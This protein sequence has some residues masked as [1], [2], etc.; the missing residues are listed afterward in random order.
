MKTCKLLLLF[1]LLAPGLAGAHADPSFRIRQNEKGCLIEIPRELLG[2]DFLLGARVV[3]VSSTDSRTK[4]YAGQRLYDPVWV[5]FRQEGEQLLLLRPGEKNVCADTT[6]VSYPAYARNAVTPVAGSWRIEQQSDSSIIVNWT[7]LFGEPMSGV[8]PF[9]GRN[10]EGRLLSQFTRVEPVSAHPT[11]LE[12]NVRYVFEKND[13]TFSTVVRKSLLVLPEEPMKP[14]ID[15]PRVGYDLVSKRIY[16]LGDPSLHAEDYIT[17]FRIVPAPEDVP[18]YLKGQKVK[19]QQPI[20]F[21]IDDAFPPLWK[22]AIRE[23]ILDWNRAFEKIGF[24]E[25]LQTK[26]YAE[27]GPDFDPDDIR[28]NCFRYVVSDFPNAMG[29]HWTDPRSGEILQA[30][31]L[32]HSEVITLLQRWLFLQTA[33]YN[34]DARCKQLPDRVV[35]RLIRY[36]AAHEIGHCLGLEH[37]F[38]A[39]SAYDTESLRDPEFTK[40]CGTTPSIMDYAR[41]NYVAQPGDGVT[42]VYPPLLGPYDEYAIRTGYAYLPDGEEQ[43]VTRW[44]DRA[45]A[46]P[47]LLYGR[48]NPSIV[49]AD[50]TVQSSD[51]G[52]DPVA[53]ASCGT[54]NLRRIL[55]HVAEWNRDRTTENPFEGMPAGYDDLQ[56]AYFDQLERVVPFIGGIVALEGGR[57]MAKQRRFIPRDRSELAV[58]FLWEE[59]I[60]GHAFLHTD[61]VCRYAGDQ[62]VAIV[63]ARKQIVEKMFSRNVAEQI[64]KGEQQTSFGLADYLELSAEA[65]FEEP[66]PDL[67]LRNLQQN[68]IDT[69]KALCKDSSDS[70]YGVLIAPA[71]ADH[72]ALLR[73]KFAGH[74]SPWNNH[75]KNSLP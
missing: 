71:V 41:F 35:E 30:D 19:P 25:V 18:R 69:L 29:K 68:Y 53:S 11:N 66:S 73:E 15:D 46:D 16:D 40:R 49:P 21:H 56:K 64:C 6:H 1:W 75:L 31:V 33:A 22:K 45:Q 3:S 74:P 55:V 23:G 61:S 7:T 43:T 60:R 72:F 37:N 13:R 5:R 28:Y 24:K 9:G 26:T 17:R 63:K 67:Y 70:V 57:E 34:P 58:R 52:N 39:S 42:E 12:V 2:R 4:L 50:P 44:I 27:S 54:A 65:L 32:F 20:V 10:S 14:R 38:R 62:T 36:A 47:R 8:D 48:M 59:L 51:L